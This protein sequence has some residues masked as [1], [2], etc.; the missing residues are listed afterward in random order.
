MPHTALPPDMETQIQALISRGEH[1]RA[2]A[3]LRD[4][5]MADGLTR[6]VSHTIV[7]CAE[8]LDQ[9]AADLRVARIALLG[10]CTLDPLVPLLRARAL[11]VR[12]VAETYV[13]Q[14]NAWQQEVLSADSGLRHFQPDVIFLAVRAEDVV[15]ALVY[16]F[17]Q[18]DGSGVDA[19]IADAAAALEG[20]FTALRQWSKAKVVVHSFPCPAFPA[21]G[22]LDH[23]LPS[24]QHAAFR[25]LNEVL[26]A[27]AQRAGDAWVIDCEGLIRDVG[28]SRWQDPR[29]WALAKVPFSNVALERLTVEYVKY[30]GAFW[31]YVRKVLV[32]DLDN[33]LWG[34]V[35]GED[36]L[37]AIQ[38]GTEYPGSAFVDL[39][40][41]IL[42]LYDRGVVLAINS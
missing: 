10:S 36:G 22:I 32:L 20:F 27:V 15:P 4:L 31:G 6:A 19:Q 12:I 28:W 17:L 1:F 26:A 18:L 25:K 23:H 24:G 33:T 9:T 14:F 35:I 34:G 38:L 42:N 29:L 11:A 8:Q 5:V 40:R 30:L 13:G 3:Q 16:R 21:L 7:K 39:Q 2:W 41:A 37:Q